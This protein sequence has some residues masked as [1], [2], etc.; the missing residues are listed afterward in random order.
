MLED[1]V[2]K[3]TGWRA[4]ALKRPVA[5]KTGTT[6]EYVDAW[7]IGYTP[8]LATGVWVGHDHVRTLGDEETGSRAAAPIW[9]SFMKKALAEISPFDRKNTAAKDRKN[10]VVP[11]RI[12]TAVID[13]LTGLLATNESQKMVEF[14][15][16]GSVPNVYS[17]E[18]YRD[19][20][21]KQQKQLAKIK[22]KKKKKKNEKN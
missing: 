16:E 6:N 18:M 14:F 3:G 19:L 13:P 2:K 11:D 21:I 5:G 10:F 4:K 7:F 8:E 22:K 1:V 17:T 12:V 9:V 20:L 15:N